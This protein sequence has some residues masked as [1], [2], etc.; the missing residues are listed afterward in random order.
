MFG[1]TIEDRDFD[2]LWEF[3][4]VLLRWREIDTTDS[5]PGARSLAG[6]GLDDQTG[7]LFLFGG[8]AQPS[9]RSFSDGWMFQ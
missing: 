8:L 5:R 4:P 3:D 6:F 2:E 9:Y 7:K 1:G